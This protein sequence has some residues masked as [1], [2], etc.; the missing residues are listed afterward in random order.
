MAYITGDIHGHPD[1]LLWYLDQMKIPRTQDQIIVL[2]GDVG[3]NY[4]LD[5]RDLRVKKKL[6][7]SGRTY[8]CIHGNHEERPKN[9]EGYQKTIWHDGYVW[10][11]AAYPNLV[12]AEDGEMYRIDGKKC[13]AL[14][15]AY[16][17]DKQYRILTHANWFQDEQIA[18]YER[19]L[20]MEDIK[21]G[22]TNDVDVV[23][24]HTCP[25]QW[26]PRDLF[27]PGFDQDTVDTSMELWLSEVEKHL[28][29]KKWYFAHYHE[30]RKINPKVQMLFNSVIKL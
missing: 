17:I 1:D 10:K 9:I 21:D 6:Q 19:Q 15:G 13:L 30:N 5:G 8:F 16:S 11:E 3:A 26:Q 12:F 25:I 28:N 22:I 2:L 29:Y 7:E 20:I 23:F 4:Y 27:L 24:S 18:P 14:G